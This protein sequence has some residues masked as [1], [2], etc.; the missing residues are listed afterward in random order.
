MSSS[1][2][3]IN[4]PSKCLPYE[5][6]NPEDIT[7]RTYTGADEVLLA[8]INPVNIERNFL[9]VLQSVISGID[10]KKLTLGDRLYLILWEYINSYNSQLDVDQV[11]SHCLKRVSFSVDLLDLQ[12]RYLP[13]NYLELTVVHL[14]VQDKVVRLRVLTVEDEVECE[15]MESDGKDP[16]LYRIARSFVG[17]EEPFI[18]MEKMKSWPGK[19]MARVRKFHELDTEHGPKLLMTQKC[20]NCGEEEDVVI[21]FRFEYFHPTGEALRKCFGA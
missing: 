6:I 13:D 17:E 19:D 16:Y 12:L 4:L 10:P 21:P 15:K 11:C 2:L 5:G 14:P 1:F 8:Q 18:L 3:P 9:V 20:P 7:V